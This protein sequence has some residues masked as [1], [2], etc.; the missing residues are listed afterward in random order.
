E[1]AIACLQTPRRVPRSAQLSAAGEVLGHFG[2][3]VGEDGVGAGSADG[4]EGFE[5]GGLAVDPAVG[6]GGL[7]H[8]VLA[9]DVVRGDRDVHVVADLADDVEVGEGR[10]H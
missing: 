8:R 10:L 7:D 6:G 3:P 4:G 2:G 9:G 5:D 1:Q